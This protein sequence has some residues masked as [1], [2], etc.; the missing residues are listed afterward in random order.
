MNK[1]VTFVSPS[2]LTVSLALYHIK[3]A[4]PWSGAMVSSVYKF[5]RNNNSTMNHEGNQMLDL[6]DALGLAWVEEPRVRSKH[7]V[8]V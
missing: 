4:L 8:L 5:K 7:S 3:I 6:I 1:L 2:D